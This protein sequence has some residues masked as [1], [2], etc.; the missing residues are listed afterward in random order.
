MTEMV[1]DEVQHCSTLDIVMDGDAA[2]RYLKNEGEYADRPRPDLIMLDFKMPGESGFE[3]LR[4]IRQTPGFELVPVVLCSG[5][6]SP[7]D[8]R[9]AY[10]L[11]ANGVIHKPGDLKEFYRVIGVCYEFWCTAAVLP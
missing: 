4:R 8:V 3:V 7:A 2:L 10:E 1:H 6:V 5:L 11:G 9:K